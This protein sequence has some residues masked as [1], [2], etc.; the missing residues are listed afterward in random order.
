[1]TKTKKFLKNI[2][3]KALPITTV[4]LLVVAILTS[5]FV[6]L[7]SEDKFVSAATVDQFLYHKEIQIDHDQVPSV[8][9]NFPVLIKLSSDTDLAAD[10]LDSGYD[11]A[12]FASDQETQLNHEI[13]YF[14][15]STGALVAWVNVTSLSSSSN[16]TIYMYYGDSDIGSTAESVT[17]TWHS[18]YDAVWH[19][20]EDS[21]SL[22]DSTSNNNDGTVTSAT[23]GNTGQID[24]DYSFDGS[25]DTVDVANTFDYGT[26]DFSI[27]VFCTKDSWGG[28]TGQD[29]INNLGAGAVEWFNIQES[30]TDV[31]R[32]RLDD[33]SSQFDAETASGSL[34]GG[35]YY[36]ITGVRDSG[37]NTYLFLNGSM[38]DSTADTGWSLDTS[39]N[40]NIGSRTDSSSWWDGDIDECRI[41]HK[42]LDQNYILTVY[43]NINNATSGFISLGSEQSG[44]PVEASEFGI[45]QSYLD[46]GLL[47]WSGRADTTTY[48]NE[49]V[50]AG[51][52]VTI[53]TDV[54]VSEN[55]TDIYIDLSGDTAFGG[56]DEVDFDSGTGNSDMW[57]QVGT[58]D[59][60][61]DEWVQFTDANSYNISLNTSWASLS[62]DVNPFVIRNASGNVTITCIFRLDIGAGISAGTYNV[63]NTAWEVVHKYETTW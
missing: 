2:E 51:N 63:A 26:D 42:V 44:E 61:S 52:N 47:K 27:M 20:N 3:A 39:V 38:M 22:L 35:T 45:I 55:C 13:E 37:T 12:F 7:P 40:L 57:L 5:V 14:N 30:N 56:S 1:M 48:S 6:I 58:D 28:T 41:V 19:F 15:G 32:F 9:S 24:G 8:Q 43:N 59:T 49:T 16:T 17:G 18:M 23:Q 29:L 36:L 11:I 34:V 31:L 60:W 21:G 54:N 46:S 62:D 33:G 25:D 50:G 10:A 53:Y 4:F